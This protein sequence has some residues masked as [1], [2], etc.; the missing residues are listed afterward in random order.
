M[1]NRYVGGGRAETENLRCDVKIVNW[2]RKR[3]KSHHKRGKTPFE[4]LKTQPTGF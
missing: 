4:A 1:Q 3:A 2:E